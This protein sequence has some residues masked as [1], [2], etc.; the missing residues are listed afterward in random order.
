MLLLRAWKIRTDLVMSTDV[1]KVIVW[2]PVALLIAV[3]DCTT[4][5]TAADACVAGTPANRMTQT[6]RSRAH[7][8]TSALGK[9]CRRSAE[10]S[11]RQTESMECPM[12]NNTA[13]TVGHLLVP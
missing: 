4:W 12:C 5:I 9:S 10:G 1:V 11:R 2:M 13:R 8:F 7:P 3:P 6:D